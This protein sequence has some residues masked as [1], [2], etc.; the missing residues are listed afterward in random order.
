MSPPEPRAPDSAS[1]PPTSPAS[2]EQP[3]MSTEPSPP[4]SAPPSSE[5]PSPA[6]PA[7]APAASTSGRSSGAERGGGAGHATRV[8]AVLLLLGTGVALGAYAKSGGE[9]KPSQAGGAGEA[10]AMPV[11][12][13]TLRAEDVPYEPSTLARTNA[14]H[15]VEVRSRVSGYLQRR[16]FVE[17]GV[18]EAGQRLFQVDPRPLQR[19][20]AVHRARLAGA[21]ARRDRASKQLKRFRELSAKRAVTTGEVEEWEKEQLVAAA[22]VALHQAEI[23]ATELDLDYASIEAPVAGR[24][25]EAEVDAG[26]YVTASDLLAVV[27]QVDPLHV[28]F[29][30]TEQIM[31]EL[32]SLAAAG[33]LKMPAYEQL[34]L[35]VSLGDGRA[36]PYVGQVDYSDP[37]LS[38]ATATRTFRGVVPNPEHTLRPG[39]FVTVTVKGMI[40]LGVLRVPQR[41]V[42]HSPTGASVYVVG[43]DSKV[44]VRSVELADWLGEG[45][46]V[47]TKGLEP[48]EQVITNRLMTLRPGAKV[49]PSEAPARGAGA[50]EAEAGEAE[51]GEAEA[52]EAP[53]ASGSRR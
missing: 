9:P 47:V 3:H 49:A 41:A 16:G 7:A 21:E 48:G 8:A 51:A 35:E 36:H 14:S 50:G 40:R 19:E 32:E 18:V 44:E 31:L 52:S 4:S 26:S 24:I 6:P 37:E 33:R 30:V 11:L 42:L 15:V 46:W 43:K 27:R 38:S 12:V 53:V 28:H 1:S 39:Q 17:G 22:E 13:R 20:L 10:P 2:L 29:S 25:G 34:R 23:D 45:E 5:S